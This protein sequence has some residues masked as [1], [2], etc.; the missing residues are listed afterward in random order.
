M[1]KSEFDRQVTFLQETPVR[2]LFCKSKHNEPGE[3]PEYLLTGISFG[4]MGSHIEDR[5]VFSRLKIFQY[6]W[7]SNVIQERK[8]LYDEFD[9]IG[10]S[11]STKRTCLIAIYFS[12]INLL[13]SC[14]FQS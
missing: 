8:G 10:F 5:S 11:G 2:P 12:F 9:R 13:I 7:I 1:P 14:H 4:D 3:D 6:N